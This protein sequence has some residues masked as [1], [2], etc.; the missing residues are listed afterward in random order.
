MNGIDIQAIILIFL[1]VIVSFGIGLLVQ[2]FLDNRTIIELINEVNRLKNSVEDEKKKADDLIVCHD[3]LINEINQIKPITLKAFVKVPDQCFKDDEEF[4]ANIK[5]H[6]VNLMKI[7]LMQNM[8]IKRDFLPIENVHFI[9][10]K[11]SII[12]IRSDNSNFEKIEIES[13]QKNGG[14]GNA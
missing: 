10:G 5:E 4:E 12:P 2:T 9:Q 13:R 11:L 3:H 14:A 6:F 8:T 7:S 1:G